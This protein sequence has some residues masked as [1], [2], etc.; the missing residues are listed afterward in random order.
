MR[1]W[2]RLLA[3]CCGA[4]LGAASVP[5]A[6]ARDREPM[7]QA[8]LIAAVLPAVVNVSTVMVTH[9][10]MTRAAQDMPSDQ[11]PSTGRLVH[12]FGSGFIID[13]GGIIVTN[14]H[15]IENA[16]QISIT[17]QDNTTMAASRVGKLSR[18][19]V[20]LLR[21]QPAM[22]LPVVK[23]GDSDKVRVGE[24]V[25]A[26]GNP[27][28]LGGSVS[29]GIVSA[30]NR[31]IR[32]TPFDDFIQT[33]AAINHGSSGG[34]L[35]NMQGLVIGINTA[36]YSPTD[37]SGSIGISFAL[38]INDAKF[39]IDQTLRYGRV[40]PGWLGV[41]MQSITPDIAAAIGLGIPRGSIV[42]GVE[43]NGPAARGGVQE[44]D[45]IL[46]IGAKTARDSREVWRAIATAPLGKPIELTV[47]RDGTVMTLSPVVG[48]MTP[49]PGTD[50]PQD[51]GIHA[52][53]GT[54]YEPGFRLST[55]TSQLRAKYK[56]TAAAK[57]VLVTE[58]MPDSP[59][60]ERGIAPGDVIV[61]VG[62][63]P[64]SKPA[65]IDAKIAAG[66]A[67][68]DRYLLLLVAGESGRRFV[69]LPLQPDG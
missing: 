3:V 45:V 67:R 63:E 2:M 28:G 37:E 49:P 29:S 30:L 57:G 10:P 39:I 6:V 16:L 38:P 60:Y 17:L 44:G 62:A 47:W 65:D 25:L 13:K 21:V 12:G 24:P 53:A 51:A 41:S 9:T 69:T 54:P 66:R 22:P 11:A 23:L 43:P 46:S 50:A 42:A 19:D 56:L 14:R 48:E 68:K 32:T 36:I 61:R 1:Q 55:V 59:A 26:I 33:D 15:V 18:A 52:V 5:P 35:F 20:A 58:V 4:S 8:D 27:L 34:P 7:S 31:D 40:R 64:V